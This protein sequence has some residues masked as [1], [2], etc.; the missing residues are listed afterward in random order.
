LGQ[1]RT[2]PL[3]VLFPGLWDPAVATAIAGQLQQLSGAYLYCWSAAAQQWLLLVVVV[4][5][6]LLQQQQLP[7]LLLQ[8]RVS[9]TCV[10]KLAWKMSVTAPV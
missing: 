1:L 7:L 6:L 10:M 9:L 4:V 8:C 3:Q 5:V 2:R